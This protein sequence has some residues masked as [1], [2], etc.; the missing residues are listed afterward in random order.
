MSQVVIPSCEERKEKQKQ[1]T[2]PK[3]TA[4]ITSALIALTSV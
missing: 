3:Q 4:K 2:N 1:K